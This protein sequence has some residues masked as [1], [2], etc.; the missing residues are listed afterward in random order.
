MH[1]LLLPLMLM[2][3]CKMPIVDIPFDSDLDGLLD[4]EE[5]ELG[6]DPD[7]PDTDGDS[8]SDS[9]ELDANTDPLDASSHPYTGGWPIDDCHNDIQ[10]TGYEIGDIAYPFELMDQYGDY[11]YLYD[12][13]AHAI[14]IIYGSGT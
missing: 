13:C 14:Y 7:N 9:D 6:T 8:F 5:D 12:F 1:A 3:A 10:G 2:G 11:V 4:D